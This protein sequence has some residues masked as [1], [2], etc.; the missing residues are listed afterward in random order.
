MRRRCTSP[1]I[2]RKVSEAIFC[3]K[4]FNNEQVLRVSAD[5]LKAIPELC[6]YIEN[7]ENI[8]TNLTTSILE[9]KTTDNLRLHF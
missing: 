5:V 3:K 1:H 4:N 2:L 8:F 6:N 7:D 9:T